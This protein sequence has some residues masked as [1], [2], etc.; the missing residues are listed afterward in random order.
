MKFIQWLF[1][2]S[3]VP[4]IFGRVRRKDRDG[5]H[6]EGVEIPQKKHF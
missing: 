4:S 2:L 1:S 6:S 5:R 3:A